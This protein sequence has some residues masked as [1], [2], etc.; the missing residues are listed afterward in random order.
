[1][2]NPTKRNKVDHQIQPIKISKLRASGFQPRVVF[3][4]ESLDELATSIRQHG[5]LQP[6]LVQKQGG[7]YE[8][9]AGERRFRAAQLAGLKEVPCALVDFLPE[10]SFVVALVENLQ[11][12]DLNPLEEARAFLRLQEKLSLSQEEIAQKVGKDRATITNSLRLLRLPAEIQDL[13]STQS[14]SSGHARSLL[15][16]KSPDM[17]VMV[18]QKIIREGMSVR[19]VESLVRSL[20]RAHDTDKKPSSAEHLALLKELRSKLEYLFGSQVNLQKQGDGYALTIQCPTKEDFNAFLD[21]F[22]IKL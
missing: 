5:I 7:C 10:E 17:M 9:I 8:I 15:S 13:V 4:L 16:L 11:R 20:N 18:A 14:L 12:E 1:M 6:L 19:S 2:S 21:R 22:D 3:S